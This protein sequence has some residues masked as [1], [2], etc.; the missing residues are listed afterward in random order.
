LIISLL[1]DELDDDV[2][3][4][5]LIDLLDLFM[6]VLEIEVF[7]DREFLLLEAELAAEF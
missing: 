2:D 6:I 7:L 5:V 4:D 3:D 1:N